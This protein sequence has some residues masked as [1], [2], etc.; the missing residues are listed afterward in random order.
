M[1]FT[2]S[3]LPT[4]SFDIERSY[5]EFVNIY[6]TH[7]QIYDTIR[8]FD[9]TTNEQVYWIAPRHPYFKSKPVIT[10]I[11]GTGVGYMF[12]NVTNLRKYFRENSLN[13]CK[14]WIV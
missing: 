9:I 14:Y 11:D 6:N 7:N 5:V 10:D 1:K 13:N 12:N 8:I 3:L 4:K 2:V